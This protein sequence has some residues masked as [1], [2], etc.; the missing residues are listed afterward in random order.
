MFH[1][2]ISK[3]ISISVPF[4]IISISCFVGFLA[5]FLKMEM[6]ESALRKNSLGIC[7]GGDGQA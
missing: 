2:L 6:G 3:H 4:F 1:C 7:Q 5:G